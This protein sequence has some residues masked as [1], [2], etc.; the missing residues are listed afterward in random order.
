MSEVAVQEPWDLSSIGLRLR[1]PNMTYETFEGLCE[2]L[3]E[4]Y[5]TVQEANWALKF[6]IGDAI[7]Q[8]EAL[9]GH[10]SYQAF[11][12]FGM[13]EEV[14]RECARVSER[15]PRSSR[16]KRVPW[17][18][19]RAV[20]AQEPRRQKELLRQVAEE[21]LSHH[22]LRDELRNGAEP[23]QQTTCRCCGRRL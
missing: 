10:R 3:G 16:R 2:Y 21:G 23:R 22:A 1:D 5:S 9:F 11:E 4:S 20:A 14:Q 7:I 19:H 17:S 13:S 15:V 6:A 8:G 12:R 18:L